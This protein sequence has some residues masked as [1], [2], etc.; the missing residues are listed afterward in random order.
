MAPTDPTPSGL[1]GTDV[2]VDHLLHWGAYSDTCRQPV[3]CVFGWP[4]GCRHRCKNLTDPRLDERGE[5]LL[6]K[7]DDLIDPAIPGNKTSGASSGTTCSKR[8]RGP[9]PLPGGP[10]AFAPSA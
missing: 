10:A 4:S 5:R 3:T 8:R 2:D 7:R 6:L 9:W 1:D